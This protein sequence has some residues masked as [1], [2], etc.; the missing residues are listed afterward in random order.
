MEI[1][2]NIPNI[3]QSIIGR[4]Y[5]P[6]DNSYAVNLTDSSNYPYTNENSYLAGTHGG[7]GRK[8][9]TIVSEP[10]LCKIRTILGDI[11]Q[12]PMIVVESEG[13]HHLTLFFQSNLI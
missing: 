10:F 4:Q 1:T 5:L 12:H 3:Y 11:R 6:G 9:V 7:M 13:K 8:Q 2:L